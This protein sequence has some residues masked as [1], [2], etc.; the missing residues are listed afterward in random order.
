MRKDDFSEI[1]MNIVNG[2]HDLVIELLTAGCKSKPFTLAHRVGQLVGL[3][4]EQDRG[5]DAQRIITM[6][7]KFE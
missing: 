5:H 7:E 1:K 6:L 2:N 3:L 4:M